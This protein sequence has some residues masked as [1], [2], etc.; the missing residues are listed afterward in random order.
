MSPGGER[1][2]SPTLGLMATLKKASRFQFSCGSP[3]V[4]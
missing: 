1:V 2:S 4:L 3:E